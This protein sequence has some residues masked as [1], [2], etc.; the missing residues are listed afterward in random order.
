MAIKVRWSPGS[1]PDLEDICHFMS[2]DSD[3][4]ARMFAQKIFDI[5][6]GIPSFPESGRIVPDYNVRTSERRY[7]RTTALST[8]THFKGLSANSKGAAGMSFPHV[9]SHPPD[10]P[11]SLSDRAVYFF[12]SNQGMLPPTVGGSHSSKLRIADKNRVT[13]SGSK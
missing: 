8:P 1:V 3:Y 7:I 11:A 12:H 10:R 5:V 6:E 4:Y 2:K 9:H 13:T